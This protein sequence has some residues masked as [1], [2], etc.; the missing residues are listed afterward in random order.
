MLEKADPNYIVTI[1]KEELATLPTARFDKKVVTVEREEDIREA[2]DVLRKA[3]VLGF[4]TE[5]KPN[6]KKGHINNVALLQLSTREVCYLF[7]LN[8]IGLPEPVRSL[9]EDPE[10]KKI[11]LSIHDDFHNLR[12][13]GELNPAGFIDLQPYVKNF[14]IADNS[15]TRIYAILFGQRISK[16]QQ[17]TNWEA[18]SLTANQQ[19]YAALDA[20]ACIRI[21]DEISGGHFEPLKSPYYRLPEPKAERKTDMKAERKPELKPR[22]RQQSCKK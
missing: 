17:L 16:G 15:L 2:V 11:G 20:L 19:C 13:L 5:T 1:T 7:R 18:A 14:L 10:I 21:F 12:R 6:F 8:V 4:D 9:L 22:R 3:D